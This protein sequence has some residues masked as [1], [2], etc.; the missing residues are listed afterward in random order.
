MNLVTIVY[1][2][3]SICQSTWKDTS[4]YSH[5][6]ITIALWSE[7]LLRGQTS[8]SIYFIWRMFCIIGTNHHMISHSNS[9]ETTE[10]LLIYFIFN[11]IRFFFPPMSSSG[12]CTNNSCCFSCGLHCVWF[13]SRLGSILQWPA[14]SWP[15]WLWQTAWRTWKTDWRTWWWGPAALDSPSPQRTWCV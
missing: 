14:R 6:G 1:S 11:K 15:S 7:K 13:S 3:S 12:H 8:H 10:F 5:G 4:L 9:H 2:S